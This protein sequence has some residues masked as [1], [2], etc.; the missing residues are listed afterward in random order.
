[1][2]DASFKAAVPDF[3]QESKQLS[4]RRNYTTQRD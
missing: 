3:W 4:V 2:P 1:V